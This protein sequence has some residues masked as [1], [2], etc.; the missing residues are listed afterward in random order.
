MFD[1]DQYL[2]RIGVSADASLAE[3]HRAH[4]VAIPFENLDS[5]RGLAVSVDPAAISAKLV[6]NERGGYCFEHNL[7]LKAA[8]EARGAIVTPLLARPRWGSPPGTLNSLTHL[9]L[10][11]A[12]DDANWLADVGF[13][14]GTL[15]EPIP[16]APGEADAQSGWRFRLIEEAGEL[17]LQT[18]TDEGW[19]DMYAISPA[20]VAPVDIEMANWFVCSRP[21]SR[22][23][24]GLIV[25]Q[26]LPDGTRVALSDWNGEL[27]LSTRAVSGSSARTV[28]RA[29]I[30]S[31]LA[32]AFEMPGW[33]VGSDGRVASVKP[34]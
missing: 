2:A 5:H 28:E 23:V 30:A 19:R 9:V 10:R 34:A 26:T 21:D 31:V 16:F 14:A 20:P 13:G 12:L 3:L 32:E 8:L 33:Y 6:G 24:N 17:V 4:V 11:V 18:H 15:L 22:F 7:L 29:A 1:L 27:T 25:T